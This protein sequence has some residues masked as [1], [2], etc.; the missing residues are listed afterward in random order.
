[1]PHFFVYKSKRETSCCESSCRFLP[2]TSNS[3][4]TIYFINLPLDT[5]ICQFN[6]SLINAKSLSNIHLT[7]LFPLFS[8]RPLTNRLLY[9]NSVGIPCLHHH[10]YIFIS[11]YVPRFHY[12]TTLSDLYKSRLSSP[13]SILN[14]PVLPAYVALRFQTFV[15]QVNH[16][17][18]A[19]GSNK[20]GL[21]YYYEIA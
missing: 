10:S 1:M 6:P 4:D 8:Q 17:S 7:L 2:V 11:C 13:F 9:Q 16:K 20:L 3:F 14:W 21:L 5:I 15:I 12:L 18:Q 19:Q